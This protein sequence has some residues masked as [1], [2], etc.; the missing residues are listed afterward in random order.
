MADEQPG[1]PY[2]GGAD[3]PA[4]KYAFQAWMIVFLLTICVGLLVFLGGYLK[5]LW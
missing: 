4:Y 2:P 1:H 5:N 3:A